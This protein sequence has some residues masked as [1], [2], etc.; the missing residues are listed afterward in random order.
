[1]SVANLRSRIEQVSADISQHKEALKLDE[2]NKR[3]LQRQLN[4]LLDPVARLPLEISSE[5]FRHCLPT[6]PLSEGN[7]P[8]TICMQYPPAVPSPAAN[9]APM[10]LLNICGAWTKIAL[11]APALWANI[12]AQFPRSEGF[13]E[14]FQT[15]LDRA[16]GCPLNISL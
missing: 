10:I 1:M 12:H 6:D 16:R 13:K 15:W 8:L 3:E 14:L 5:I 2:H 7:L 9:H 11:S 4:A